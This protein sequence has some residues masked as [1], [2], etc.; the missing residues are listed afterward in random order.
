MGVGTL[1]SEGIYFRLPAIENEIFHT[2]WSVMTILLTQSGIAVIIV[3]GLVGILFPERIQ[4]LELKLSEALT[5]GI[6]NPFVSFLETEPYLRM[7]RTFGVF[8]LLTAAAAEYVL[9]LG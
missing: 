7:V 2:V 5:L 6:P 1:T 4:R 9:F 3:I 8:T